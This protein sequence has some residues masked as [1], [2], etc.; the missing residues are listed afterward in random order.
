MMRWIGFDFD[1]IGLEHMVAR[2][3]GMRN[4]GQ[5]NVQNTAVGTVA[6][7]QVLWVEP[8]NPRFHA[9]TV[10][11]RSGGATGPVIGT[12]RNLDLEPLNLPAGTVVYAEVRDPVGPDGIDWV[13]NP[14][15]NNTATDSGFNGSRFVQS[16]TFTV[17]DTH[18][19]GFAGRGRHHRPARPTRARSRA[20]SSSTSTPTTR[21]TA[22]SRSPGRSTA[23]RSRTRPTA[24]R[25]ISA[26]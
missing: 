25:S 3:T 19:D 13:R 5:M 2:V 17:G 21:P 4:S 11:W 24:A 8:G 18:R 10:T 26:R 23:P 22:S 14:S 9:V 15:T 12:G 6:K 20:T 1:Q 7:D 16:R